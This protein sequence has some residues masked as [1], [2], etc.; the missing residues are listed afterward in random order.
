[1]I[2]LVFIPLSRLRPFLFLQLITQVIY[3]ILSFLL[4]PLFSLQGVM[5]SYLASYAILSGTFYLYLKRSINF[6]FLPENRALFLSSLIALCLISLLTSLKVR[7]TPIVGLG[8]LVIWLKVSITVRERGLLKEY[9][10]VK[11]T[12]IF[13]KAG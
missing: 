11:W 9:L 2:G 1:M 4:L 5:I 12:K 10:A 7:A 3:V 6:K 8:L 13:G